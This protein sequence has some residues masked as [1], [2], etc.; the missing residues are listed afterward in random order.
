[1]ESV[2]IRAASFAS[3]RAMITV[4]SAFDAELVSDDDGNYRVA[5]TLGNDREIVDVL[6]TLERYVSDRQSG[7]ERIVLNGREYTIYPEPRPSQIA[8]T[9]N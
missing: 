9:Q 8:A 1:M 4:L 2:T 6:S 5:V 7:C 3:G